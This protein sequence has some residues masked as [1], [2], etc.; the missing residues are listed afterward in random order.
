V[1]DLVGRRDLINAVALNSTM[2]NGARIIGPALGG[3]LVATVGEGWCFFVNGISFL[4]VLVALSFM[5]VPS[6]QR[7]PVQQH[8]VAHMAAGLAY[9]WRAR[10]VRALLALLGFISLVGLPYAVLMPVISDKVLHSGPTGLGILMGS[11]GVGALAAALTL[12]ARKTLRG[13]G[14]WIFLC[15]VG[16]GASLVLFSLSRHFWLSVGLLVP[17]GYS[18]MI[19]M[20]ASNTLLQAMVP[21][22]LRGRVMAV[23]SMMFMGMAPFGALL[24]GV[25]ANQIGTMPTIATGGLACIAVAGV[26]GWH[27]PGL[28]TEARQ[29][30]LALE[31]AAGQPAE[32]QTGKPVKP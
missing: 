6:H 9:A 26:F 15:S 18:M 1:A 7:S 5:A 10:P 27:L 3:M 19:T 2:F 23:Y 8:V 22:H 4:A 29:M 30:I 31:M 24:A 21:D 17:V 20:A 11:A 13:L 12:T 32:Q 28:R 25:M 14:R 16:L